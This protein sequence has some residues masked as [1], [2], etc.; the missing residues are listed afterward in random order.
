MLQ[1]MTRS[2]FDYHPQ[3]LAGKAVV[4]TGGTTGIG[5]A[6]ALRLAS[7]GAR[8]LIFGRHER[9]LND[10]LEDLE[11]A[12]EVHGVTADQARHEDVQRVFKEADEQLG[13]VDILINNAAVAGGTVLESEYSHWLYV[14]QSNLVG[15][16]DCCR[17]A[18]ARMRKKGEGHI[19]NIGSLSAK[20]RDAGEDVYTATK[21]GIRG[22]TESFRKS[23]N[24]HGIKVTLIEPGSVGTDMQEE[25]VAEQ[26]QQQEAL[27]MLK[28]EDIAE[29]V[30]YCLVQPQRCDLIVVQIR[31]HLQ[32]I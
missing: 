3:N 17:Q 16:I 14:I 27:E 30:H 21:S 8:V 11:A 23:V 2:R 22:F 24:K 20:E 5:R 26:R 18:A 10:A 29:C 1:E 12:G 6:T 15:Y 32:V 13:G 25:S 4:I 19:V 28:A 9:E 31:P 7:D